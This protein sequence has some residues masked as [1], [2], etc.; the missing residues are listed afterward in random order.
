MTF[1]EYVNNLVL[2]ISDICTWIA[3]IAQS[4]MHNFVFMTLLFI[5]II[6]FIANLIYKIVNKSKNKL[7]DE[8]DTEEDIAE[9]ED[10]EEIDFEFWD[11]WEDDDYW[12]KLGLINV[13]SKI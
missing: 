6:V 4:L 3:D 8:E 7:L 1:S 11:D 5:T 12:L 13:N 10:T 2:I 9:L